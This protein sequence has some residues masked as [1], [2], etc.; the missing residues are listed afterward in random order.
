MRRW[1]FAT[2]EPIGDPI[3]GHADTVRVIACSQL[4][5]RRIIVTGSDDQSIRVWDLA[6]G[7]PI[8]REYR[9]NSPVRALACTRLHGRPV[10]AAGDGSRIR[11]W[12]LDNGK[13]IGRVLAGHSSWLQTIACVELPT[14]PI[15]VTGADDHTVRIWDL[16]VGEQIGDPLT[17]HSGT[18]NA[19]TCMSARRRILAIYR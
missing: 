18:V 14:G 13:P 9:H 11:L 15:A 3:N 12:D 5:D 19:I 17:G 16:T 7:E 2:G 1:D 6:T 8:G 10:V 4:A